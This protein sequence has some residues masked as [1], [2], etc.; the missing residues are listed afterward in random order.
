MMNVKNAWLPKSTIVALLNQICP[1]IV[2][3]YFMSITVCL[4]CITL[5]FIICIVS[6]VKYFI[7]DNERRILE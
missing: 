1:L 6:P 3:W 5:H 2:L 4:D 7:K